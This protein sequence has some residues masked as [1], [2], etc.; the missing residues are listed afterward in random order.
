LLSTYLLEEIQ[1]KL[2]DKLEELGLKY[3]VSIYDFDVSAQSFEFA[4]GDRYPF[5]SDESTKQS[6]HEVVLGILTSWI[7]DKA[8]FI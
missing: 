3:F 5:E 2:N 7:N 6:A 4:L 8:I 1:T